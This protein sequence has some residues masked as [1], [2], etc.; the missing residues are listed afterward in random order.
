MHGRAHGA[1]LVVAVM[2]AAAACGGG[3][4]DV[5]TAAGPTRSSGAAM[6]ARAPASVPAASTTVAPALTTGGPTT[7]T[8]S[9]T[10]GTTGN[11]TTL[12]SSVPGPAGV[13]VDPEQYVGAAD[14]AELAE[15]GE[16]TVLLPAWAPEWTAGIAPRIA[17]NT[18]GAFVLVQWKLEVDHPYALEI[19]QGT[20]ILDLLKEERTPDH[21]PLSG[22]ALTTAVRTYTVTDS[23]ATCI[24]G[25]VDPV[26]TILLWDDGEDRYAVA[27][28]PNPACYPDDFSVAQ[29]VAFADSLVACDPT[30]AAL[31][32]EPLPAP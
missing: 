13:A 20:I 27:M 24:T 21:H 26:P 28:Q 5:A 14:L 18:T 10:T 16:P 3:D 15:L 23:A 6:T 19:G 1:V 8:T 9:K 25:D 32:C 12:S 2:V 22:E 30:G 29:A 17:V 4:D 11:S 7:G 31:E